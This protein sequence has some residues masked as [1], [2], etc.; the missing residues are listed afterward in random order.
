MSTFPVLVLQNE[1]Y[2]ILFMTLEK[3]VLSEER[4]S[5]IQ[6]ELRNIN[7]RTGFSN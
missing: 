4:L 7:T 5:K 2:Q 3:Q 1:E 6:S